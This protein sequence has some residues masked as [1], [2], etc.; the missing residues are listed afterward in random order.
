M[1]LF[2]VWNFCIKKTILIYKEIQNSNL[3]IRPAAF[4][5]KKNKA[6]SGEGACAHNVASIGR[7]RIWIPQP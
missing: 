7:L 6:L 2:C 3:P 4:C 5:G 1:V